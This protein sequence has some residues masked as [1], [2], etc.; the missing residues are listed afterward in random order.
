MAAR[1]APA[2]SRAWSRRSRRARC[3]ALERRAGR[4]VSRGHERRQDTAA[5]DRASG[6]LL[7]AC[8]PACLD[9]GDGAGD[10]G[11]PRLPDPRSFAEDQNTDATLRATLYAG[12]IQSTMQRHSIVPLL[13][14]RDPI[15]MVAL[16][17]GE[18][19][20]REERLADFREEIGAGSI[21][22][23]DAEGRI[24][25][26]SDERPLGSTTATRTISRSPPPTPARCS[27]SSR[28]TTAP[29]AFTTRARSRSR[30]SCSA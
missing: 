24:V 27:R 4:G 19:A 20:E 17:S 22:L 28:T 15:L 23:L 25:A 3:K 7:D 5:A 1:T 29:T 6:P 18:F 12:S 2:C 16:R 26:A 11:E 10:L 8:G 30:A 14:S 21:F 9:R 13:L